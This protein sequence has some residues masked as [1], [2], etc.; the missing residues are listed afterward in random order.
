[1]K[2]MAAAAL[3]AALALAGTAGAKTASYSCSY[4]MPGSP[5]YVT[6]YGPDNIPRF[7]AIFNRSAKFQPWYGYVPGTTRCHWQLSAGLAVYAKIVSP[8]AL[9]GR[10]ACAYMGH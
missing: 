4:K 9:Y 6:I 7:C 5:V 8:S 2:W 1:M 3:V 10:F